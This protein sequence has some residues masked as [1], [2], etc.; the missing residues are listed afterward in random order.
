MT[1]NV[2]FLGGS[3]RYSFAEKLIEAGGRLNYGVKIFSY[4]IGGCLPIG[5]IAKVIQ[6]KSFEDKNVLTDIKNVV[7]TYLIDIVIP[8]HDK[9]IGLAYMLSNKVFVPVSD[10]DLIKIFSSKKKSSIFFKENNLPFPF[11]SKKVPAI[12]KPDIGSASK[13]II[14]FRDQNKLD[15]FLKS[16]NCENY[17]VQDYASGPEYSVDCY[18]AINSSFKY[19]AVRERI[20]VLGGE[21]VKSKTVDIPEI[22]AI[23]SKI[24]KT[25]GM[26]GAITVQFI[27]DNKNNTYCIMEIN[28]RYGGGVLASYGA[29][30]QWFDIL[31]RDFLSKKQL[32]AKHSKNSYMVRSFREHFCK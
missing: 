26:C 1:I 8:F 31:L 17:E 7:D 10:K 21:V 30:V 13:G 29:G 27:Y 11:F 32:N 2:L 25:P 5:D 12:A 24:L 20:D 14:K 4:E 18:V 23:C 15:I 16:N 19:F 6:G 28:L 22:E 9:A 3:K